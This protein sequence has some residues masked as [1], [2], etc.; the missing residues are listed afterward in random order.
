MPSPIPN[1]NQVPD[2]KGVFSVTTWESSHR[3]VGAGEGGDGCE[4]PFTPE[5]LCPRRI[6]LQPAGMGEQER[7]TGCRLEM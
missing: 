3:A 7:H 4:V 5:F 1:V 2:M 6:L